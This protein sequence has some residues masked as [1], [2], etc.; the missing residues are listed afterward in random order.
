MPSRA[1]ASKPDPTA[2]KFARPV[3]ALFALVV[4]G[5]LCCG[6][7]YLHFSGRLG[8]ITH[9]AA[10]TYRDWIEAVVN[11][12]E[13]EE[14]R[15]EV[16]T[17]VIEEY[18][19]TPVGKSLGLRNEAGQVVGRFRINVA[20]VSQPTAVSSEPA[21]RRRYEVKLNGSGEIWHDTGG[22]C[23]FNGSA[24]VTYEVDFR[25]Q[26]WRVYAWFTCIDL[27]NALFD[28]THIDH[29]L[30]QLMPGIVRRAGR[31]AL[32]EALKPGFTLILDGSGESWITAGRVGPEFKPRVG[33]MAESDKDCDTLWNDLSRLERDF[34]DY[35]GPIELHEGEELRVTVE[36]QSLN[37]TENFGPDVLLLSETDFLAY[38]QRYPHELDRPLE[39]TP[40]EGGYNVQRQNFEVKGRTGRYYLLLDYTEYGLSHEQWKRQRHPGL[41]RYYVR[42]KR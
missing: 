17:R 6:T 37:A 13:N 10:A 29:I 8:G 25:V 14:Y 24:E 3:S 11:D 15:A 2:R 16:L 28:C 5:A 19:D 40:V 36:A 9:S 32:E 26:D 39:L 30:G 22:R 1:K 20:Q 35:L 18:R 12:P 34:R 7:G 38:E 41:V 27:R 21:A 4:V 33:P 31:E 42:V 23:R